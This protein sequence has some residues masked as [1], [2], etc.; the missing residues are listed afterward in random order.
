MGWELLRWF[1]SAMETGGTAKGL[2]PETNA[3]GTM[4]GLQQL[5]SGEPCRQTFA[6]ERDTKL[7]YRTKTSQR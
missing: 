6:L 3:R 5:M 2:I 4:I 1:G 7:T